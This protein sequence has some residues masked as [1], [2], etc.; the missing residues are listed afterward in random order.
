MLCLISASAP[1]PALP[2]ISPPQPFQAP[3]HTLG[4]GHVDSARGSL[5]RFACHCPR[6]DCHLLL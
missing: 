2:L 6:S 5:P 4:F 3:P 1:V